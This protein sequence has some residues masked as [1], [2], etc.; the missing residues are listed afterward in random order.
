MQAASLTRSVWDIDAGEFPTDGPV[1]DQATFLLRYA[2][3]APSSHNAQPWAF[4]VAGN[5]LT[6]SPACSSFGSDCKRRNTP[7][8]RE[9]RCIRLESV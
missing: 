3:L 4:D 7:S 6:S 9:G 8:S 1:E 5:E 2:I